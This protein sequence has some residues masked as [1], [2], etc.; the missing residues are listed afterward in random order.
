MIRSVAIRAATNSEPYV[1]VSTVFW[2]LENQ[3]IGV[4]FQEVESTSYSAAGVPV[5]VKDSVHI[6]C[7]FNLLAK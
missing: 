3:L 2:R 5:V 1:A 7:D 4:P 6:G